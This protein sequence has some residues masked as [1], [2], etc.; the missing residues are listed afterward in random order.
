MFTNRKEL[1]R[2]LRVAVSLARTQEI[3]HM[4]VI[5]INRA[6]FSPFL[7]RRSGNN[8]RITVVQQSV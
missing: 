7:L 4:L 5:E 8:G 6:T 3:T 2:D 1:K